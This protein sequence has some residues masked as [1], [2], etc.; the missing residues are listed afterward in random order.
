M[1][2]REL[3]R[4]LAQSTRHFRARLGIVDAPSRDVLT[5]TAG[6]R[7]AKGTLGARLIKLEGEVH[8]LTAGWE[9]HI[10]QL[11]DAISVARSDV[12]K[13]AT[14]HDRIDAVREELDRL[15]VRLD[16]V[17]LASTPATGRFETQGVWIPSLANLAEAAVNGLKLHFSNGDLSKPGYLN[18]CSH[19]GPGVDI[20]CPP[21]VSLPAGEGC[22]RAVLIGSGYVL[23]DDGV[24][25]LLAEC[26]RLMAPG[27]VLTIERFDLPIVLEEVALGRLDPSRIAG[28]LRSNGWTVSP[29]GIEVGRLLEAIR[30]AG[31][32]NVDIGKDD[33][34]SVAVV[35][36]EKP[37]FLN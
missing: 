27:A 31:F 23:A 21:G 13:A 14:V 12:H 35:S 34:G 6:V 28:A 4:R 15:A 36:A 10:P 7:L 33:S 9:Q 20:V 32:E 8:R 2:N 29:P 25:Q 30:D 19:V 1:I 18:V 24:G 17:L 3:K 26:F 16:L 11:L 37:N 22:A 5:A